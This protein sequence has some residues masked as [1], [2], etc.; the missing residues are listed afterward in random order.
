MTSRERIRA[1]FAGEKPDR[2]PLNVF[3]GWNPEVQ[4]RMRSRH[5]SLAAFMERYHIDIATGVLPR[6][7]FGGPARHAEIM[8]LDRYLELEPDDPQSPA[9]LSTPCDEILAV[10]VQQALAAHEQQ[11]AVFCHAWGVF[12]LSQFLFERD[13]LPGTEQALLNMALEPE[14]SKRLFFKL[15]AWTADCV[16]TAIKAGVDVIEL[17]DD[18]GQQRT[19]LFSPAMWW[20]MVYPAT[21]LI[22]ERARDFQVPVLL[23]SDG[24]VTQILD[25]ILALGVSGL[26]PVQESAGM[27]PRHVRDFFGKKVCLMGGLDTITA[28]PVMNVE[29][30]RCEVQRVFAMLK[31]DGGFIFSG[32]HMFQN[33]TDPAVI[34]AAYDRAYEL[35]PY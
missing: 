6:F 21:K 16:E 26:H 28:L 1:V 23:H 9:I 22:V 4:M 25:G 7:P 13:G 19:M 20:D 14:K 8:D 35:A 5:G 31:D 24:D 32:S 12:E 18:W 34:E 15:A 3:A 30:I 11:L 2:V 27:S 10:T 17:S 29:E 33:D